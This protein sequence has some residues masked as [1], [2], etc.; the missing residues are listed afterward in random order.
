MLL[1]RSEPLENCQEGIVEEFLMVCQKYSLFYYA[2]GSANFI[3][4][5]GCSAGSEQSALGGEFNKKKLK[6]DLDLFFFPFDPH[7]LDMSIIASPESS[8]PFYNEYPDN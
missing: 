4:A 5:D 7:I 3:D 8:S 6:A 2:R 1:S